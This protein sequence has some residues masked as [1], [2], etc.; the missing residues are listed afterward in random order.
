[1]SPL[2]LFPSLSAASTSLFPII[3]FLPCLVLPSPAP[4]FLLA[5]SRSPPELVGDF[6]SHN[7]LFLCAAAPETCGT[8]PA[9]L[10]SAPCRCS[11]RSI[12]I[13]QFTRPEHSWPWRQ[14]LSQCNPASLGTTF[15]NFSGGLEAETDRQP[16]INS[17]PGSLEGEAAAGGASL[18]RSHLLS[19]GANM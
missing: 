15:N 13:V 11:L 12:P 5:T 4:H 17:R 2:F 3:C 1:M 7:L 9:S 16:G 10:G 14:I 6:P 8:S 19:S 18:P